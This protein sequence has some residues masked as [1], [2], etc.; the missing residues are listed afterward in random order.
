[1][2]KIETHVYLSSNQ[3]LV[4]STNQEFIDKCERKLSCEQFAKEYVNGLKLD[5]ILVRVIKTYDEGFY[6]CCTNAEDT[7]DGVFEVCPCCDKEVF[8]KEDFTKQ[9]CPNCGNPI[10][11]CSQCEEKDCANCPLKMKPYE[12]TI[13]YC[14]SIT[15]KVLAKTEEDAYEKVSSIVSEM[16][17][18]EFVMEL[19]PQ[20]IDYNVTPLN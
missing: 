6:I 11:P 17:N 9:V 16:S 2:G 7:K 13:N 4:T 12:V 10:L 1:M 20:E 3:S 14:G 8:L 15:Q 19:E 5:N 18:H